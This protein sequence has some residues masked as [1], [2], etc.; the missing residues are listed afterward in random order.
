MGDLDVDDYML[1]IISVEFRIAAIGVDYRLAPEYKFPTQLND[2]YAALKWA[3][4]HASILSVDIAKGF[5]VGGVSAGGNMAA[6][7]A[8]RTVDD[9][10]FASRKLTGQLLGTP[11]I[12]QHPHIPEQYKSEIY[13]LEQNKDNIFI[14]ADLL[15]SIPGM[16]QVPRKVP[17]TLPYTVHRRKGFRPR[18]SRPLGG[19]RP[20]TR[21]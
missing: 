19:T 10:F 7:V 15:A 1:R 13:S 4:E 20:A 11:I 14:T 8:H 9:A 17:I 21:L 12:L 2:G 3:V 18:T 5:L 16:L 6:I